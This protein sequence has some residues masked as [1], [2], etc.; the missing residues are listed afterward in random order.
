MTSDQTAQLDL[1]IAR[2]SFYKSCAQLFQTFLNQDWPD[3]EAIAIVEGGKLLKDARSLDSFKAVIQA[4]GEFYFSK[5][6]DLE[7]QLK[8]KRREFQQEHN[9]GAQGSG[10]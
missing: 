6:I 5:A 1:I 3:I 9:Q 2:I 4:F 7:L 10:L 8:E